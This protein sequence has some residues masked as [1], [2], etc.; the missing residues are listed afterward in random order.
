MLRICQK[1]P[2]GLQSA[3]LA[4][5]LLSFLLRLSFCAPVTVST[6]DN[7]GVLVLPQAGVCAAVWQH[8]F[9]ESHSFV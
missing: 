4:F 6:P 3:A 2:R 9:E 5:L 1:P 8:L 7:V